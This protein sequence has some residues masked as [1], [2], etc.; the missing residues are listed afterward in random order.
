MLEVGFC[1]ILIAVLSEVVNDIKFIL[2]FKLFIYF[3]Y[4]PTMLFVLI[5]FSKKI[6]KKNLLSLLKP[7]KL[8]KKLQE[9]ELIITKFSKYILLNFATS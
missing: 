4:L 5:A 7:R 2:V 8:V 9:E 1:V 3:S 6:L